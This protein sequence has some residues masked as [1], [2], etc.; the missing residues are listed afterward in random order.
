[1]KAILL[2][3]CLFPFLSLTKL[4]KLNSLEKLLY[5]RRLGSLLKNASKNS[6]IF[7]LT[8]PVEWEYEKRKLMKL[9]KKCN[10]SCIII[11]THNYEGVPVFS[12]LRKIIKIKELKVCGAYAGSCVYTALKWF[13]KNAKIE[14]IY[15][16]KNCLVEKYGKFSNSPIYIYSRLCKENGI[17]YEECY[18]KERFS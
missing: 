3:H 9:L 16:I 15:S 12:P 7:V 17:E 18:Y 1:M 4:D 5:Y 2:V 14:K 10:G 8:S 13:I 6:V 11:F